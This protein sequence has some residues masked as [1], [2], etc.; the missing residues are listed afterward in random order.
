MPGDPAIPLPAAPYAVMAE[1]RHALRGFLRF[2][3]QAAATEGLTPQQHQAMLAVAGHVGAAP[4]SVGTLARQLMVTPHA[5]AELVARMV[6]AGLLEK[7]PDP[8]DRRRQHLRL[9]Q[10]GRARLARLTA[11]HLREAQGLARLAEQVGQLAA[12]LPGAPWA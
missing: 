5:A 11:A 10:A 9:T 8:A 4:P 12:A 7:Q 6:E 1:F 2:S 3:E